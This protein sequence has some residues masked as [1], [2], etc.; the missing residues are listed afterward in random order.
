MRH[1]MELGV[2]AVKDQRS[3]AS[4]V[5][6]RAASATVVTTD[7]ATRLLENVLAVPRK[8]ATSMVLCAKHPAR[9]SNWWKKFDFAG[10]KFCRKNYFVAGLFRSHCNSLYCLEMAKCCQVQRSLWNKCKWVDIKS[11]FSDRNCK[12]ENGLIECSWAEIDDSSSFVAGFYR[13][14]QHTLDGLTY[15]RKCEPYFFGAS[16]RPGETGKECSK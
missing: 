2:R 8:E 1:T 11:A 9:C 7:L 6:T 5:L 10:G 3:S 4:H 12:E 13:T 15:I 14:E 16:C